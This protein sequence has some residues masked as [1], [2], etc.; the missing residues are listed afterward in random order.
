MSNSLLNKLKVIDSSRNRLKTILQEKNVS[1][2]GN[3][4]PAL[5]EDVNGLYKPNEMPTEWNGLPDPEDVEETITYYKPGI[6]F[7]AIYVADTDKDNYSTVVMYLFKV[8]NGVLDTFG[9]NYFHNM[10]KYKFSDDGILRNPARDTESPSHTWNKTND[11]TGTDGHYRWVMGYTNSSISPDYNASYC[12]AEAMIIFK[13]T[14]TGAGIRDQQSM[15]AYI[16][17]KNA[18]TMRGVF[19]TDA[20]SGICTTLR[21]FICNAV[22]A[23]FNDAVFQNCINLEYFKC[24]SRVYGTHSYGYLFDGC[25]GLRYC[26]FTEVYQTYEC[27]FRYCKDCYIYIG[28][29]TGAYMGRDDL[30]YYAMLAQTSHIKLKVGTVTGYLGY[31]ASARDD[32]SFAKDLELDVHDIKGNIVGNGLNQYYINAIGIKIDRVGGSIGDTAFIDAPLYGTIEMYNGNDTSSSIGSNAFAGTK[33]TRFICNNTNVTTIGNYAFR[34]SDI[35]SVEINAGCGTL[36]ECIFKGCKN[37]KTFVIGDTVTSFVPNTFRESYIENIITGAGTPTIP[38]NAFRYHSRL[39]SITLAEG[40]VSLGQYAF[41][42]TQLSTIHLPAN[43]TSIPAYCFIGSDLQSVTSDG[44]ITSVGAQAFNRCYKLTS[45]DVSHLVTVNDYAFEGTNITNFEIPESLTTYTLDAF[46]Y[47]RSHIYFNEN[48]V[49]SADLSL[50]GTNINNNNILETLYSLPDGNNYTLTLYPTMANGATQDNT[51]YYD[52]IKNRT[53]TDT[54][55]GL[56]WDD[57]SSMTIA[58]YVATKHWTIV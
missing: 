20:T 57:S 4:L 16:E 9:Q 34:N 40:T 31:I 24:T 8:E 12:S 19:M 7:D 15:P 56:E 23:S 11:I 52:I 3:S 58:Q 36:G 22:T 38:D 51:H 30:N 21:T 43:V 5:I 32:A 1:I 53:I 28:T 17:V 47:M 18:V 13:G 45:M 50:A 29:Y 14:I 48:F 2:S 42:Y 37:L 39:K 33:L 35:S 41:A 10:A 26:Y 25:I 55:S 44:N 49:P 6:D 46:A 27:T 54:G